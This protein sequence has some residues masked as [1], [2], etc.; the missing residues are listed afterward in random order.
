MFNVYQYEK[1]KKDEKKKFQNL[2]KEELFKESKKSNKNI[3]NQLDLVNK[4]V[5]N[6]N[7]RLTNFVFEMAISDEPVVIKDYNTAVNNPRQIL[8]HEEENKIL[9]NYGLVLNKYLSVKERIVIY[10]LLIY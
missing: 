5:N 10:R 6:Y 3:I 7:N 4:L 2:K 8:F 9:G 1:S